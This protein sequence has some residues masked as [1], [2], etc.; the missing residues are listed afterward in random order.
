MQFLFIV[1]ASKKS[2]AGRFPPREVHEAMRRYNDQMEEAGILMA[3]EGLQPSSK[4]ARIRFQGR[5]RIVTHGPFAETKELEAGFWM[6]EV[7][8]REEAVDWAKRAPM[9]DGAE[10]EVR[11]VYLA[12]EVEEALKNAV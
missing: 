1:K 5:D 11:Q 8:S 6:V 2:E 4:G 9:E 12:K 10:L 3:A 7:A